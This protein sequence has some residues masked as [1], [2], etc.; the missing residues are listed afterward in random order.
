[1]N[2]TKSFE[3]PKT[4][5][6]HAYKKVKSNKGAAGV[7]NQCLSDFEKNLK[8]NL[9]KIWNR[10]SS[11]SYFPPP[12]KAVKAYRRNRVGNGY[13]ECRESPTVSRKW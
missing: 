4:A 13:L 9:N 7:D 6:W 8:D 2:K 11:G 1:M 12:V 10:M 5:V 3:I